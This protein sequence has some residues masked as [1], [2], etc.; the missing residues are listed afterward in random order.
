MEVKRLAH[1]LSAVGTVLAAGS[2]A[3]ALLT[4][5]PD[6]TPDSW[7]QPLHAFAIGTV[8]LGG[9]LSAIGK[10]LMAW[11]ADEDQA[12]LMAAARKGST[13]VLLVVC[14]GL[15]SGCQT[16]VAVT[17]A[18]ADTS[19][20]VSGIKSDVQFVANLIASN[21]ASHETD[22]ANRL[23]NDAIKADMVNATIA[24]SVPDATT[25]NPATAPK[26]VQV[27]PEPTRTILSNKLNADLAAI[28]IG[29]QQIYQSVLNR[30]AGNLTAAQ[31]LLQGQQQYYATAGATNSTLSSG[32]STILSLF[33]QFAPVIAN[34]IP[35]STLPATTATAT[36]AKK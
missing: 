20:A 12:N 29:Q 32:T 19:T 11:D 24:P 26:V 31:N 30:F 15:M 10:I 13:V 25:T 3:T 8:I 22:Q 1:K 36:A 7:I 35:V 18:T 27:V 9:A 4:Q 14:M 21:W 28:A 5:L 2:T 17:K 33:Q 16:S 23:Y 6:G 34:A